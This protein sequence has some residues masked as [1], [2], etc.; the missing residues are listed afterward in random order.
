[1]L[2]RHIPHASTLIPED[3]KRFF[4]I[5]A[6]EMQSEILR[7]TD[8][9]TDELFSDALSREVLF[10]VSRLVCDPERFLNDSEE[11]ASA[12]G[13]GVFYTRGTIGQVIRKDDDLLRHEIIT[14]YYQPH[15]QSL[16]ASVAENLEHHGKCLV[17]DCHS[18]PEEPLPTD[19][20]L[21]SNLRPDICLG[22]EEYHCPTDL[23]E[24]IVVALSSEGLFVT[25]NTP[26]SGSLI[27]SD[28]YKK[29]KRVL[30]LMIELNRRIYMDE[31]TGLKLDK[32]DEVRDLI[33]THI[34]NRIHSYLQN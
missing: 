7:L 1:M 30:G 6:Q 24:E 5:S 29:D 3:M 17:L 9:Y 18:F 2:V 34:L 25:I 15:H 26:Y 23:V 19:N 4:L 27:P 33:Q 12:V 13:M 22:F 20:A 16:S 32:F 10:P 11:P 31:S 28:Y 8:W 14:R 21:D